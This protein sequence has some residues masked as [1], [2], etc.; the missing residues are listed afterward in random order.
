MFEIMPFSPSGLVSLIW[1]GFQLFF[2]VSILGWVL[3]FVFKFANIK[4]KEIQK[5]SSDLMFAKKRIAKFALRHKLSPEKVEEI[6]TELEKLDP[7]QYNVFYA[8][9]KSEVFEAEIER[10]KNISTAGNSASRSVDAQKL[11]SAYSLLIEAVAN[12]SIDEDK[13]ARLRNSLNNATTDYEVVA[14]IKTLRQ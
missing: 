13:E 14:V 12:G 2:V 11:S 5:D 3:P 7:S 4:S 9:F 10:K 6:Y 8:D 1:H